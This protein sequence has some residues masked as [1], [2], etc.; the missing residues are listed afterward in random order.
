MV[1][2]LIDAFKNLYRLLKIY[3]VLMISKDYT[4]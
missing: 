1:A 2:L 4:D 3:S